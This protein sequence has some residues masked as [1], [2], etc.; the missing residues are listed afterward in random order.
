[1]YGRPIYW[2]RGKCLGGSSSI[3][4]LIFI[5]GQKEDYDHWASLGN[6]GWSWDD[7][8]P[9]FKKAEGNDRLGAPLHSQDGPLRASSIKKK[10]PLVEAFIT[11]ANQLGVPKTEDFNNLEQ[12]G[13]GAPASMSDLITNFI[14][15]YLFGYKIVGAF[16]IENALNN[17]QA[18]ILSL[19]GNMLAGLLVGGLMVYVKWRE[20][21]KEKLAKPETRT[22]TVWPHDRVG[23]VVLHMYLAGAL[24]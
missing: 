7:V 18:F 14:F 15:G 2:P 22:F 3:N 11:S 12:E 5:R 24:Y 6:A 20:K 19:E 23:E 17:T 9:Y 21:N 8:L 4:G 1:M 10:H 13:V 16:T